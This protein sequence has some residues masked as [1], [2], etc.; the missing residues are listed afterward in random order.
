VQNL[1]DQEVFEMSPML[2]IVSGVGGMG[3]VSPLNCPNVMPVKIDCGV[4]GSGIV[5]VSY[6]VFESSTTSGGGIVGG[7]VPVDEGI[8]NISEGRSINVVS[9]QNYEIGVLPLIPGEE[10]IDTVSEEFRESLTS[11]V[12]S[13]NEFDSYE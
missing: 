2:G 5:S 7:P 6:E 9:A 12:V 3:I 10:I 8:E 1:A 11:A 13:S 4:E